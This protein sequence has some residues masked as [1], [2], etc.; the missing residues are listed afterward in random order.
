MGRTRAKYFEIDNIQKVVDFGTY[1]LMMYYTKQLNSTKAKLLFDATLSEWAYRVNYDLPEGGLDGDDDLEAHFV[2]AEIQEAIAFI[3]DEL[4]PALN[5]EQEDLLVKYG[6]EDHF[7]ELFNASPDYLELLGLND[8]ELYADMPDYIASFLGRLKEVFEYAL[9]VNK[10]YI[11][12][13]H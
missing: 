7:L 1:A 13:V 11:I 10:P 8:N 6:G 12:Y 2:P 4:I 9:S 3:D 5:N